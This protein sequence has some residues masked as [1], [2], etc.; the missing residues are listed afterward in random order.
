MQVVCRQ[1]IYNSEWTFCEIKVVK[2][3]HPIQMNIYQGNTDRKYLGWPYF[4]D[5]PRIQGR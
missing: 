4:E 1:I 5:E 3:N 2:T